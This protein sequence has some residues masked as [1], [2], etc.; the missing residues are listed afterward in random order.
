[1]RPHLSP[2]CRERIRHKTSLVNA[3]V[4]NHDYMHKHILMGTGCVAHPAARPVAAAS[5]KS[6]AVWRRSWRG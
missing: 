5:G 4:P 1:V 3:V 2:A 6:S